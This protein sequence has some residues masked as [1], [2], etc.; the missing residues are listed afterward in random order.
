MPRGGIKFTF[1]I[2]R[3]ALSSEGPRNFTLALISLLRSFGV[4]VKYNVI[5]NPLILLL[6]ELYYV[7]RGYVIVFPFVKGYE[8]LAILF[9]MPLSTPS[10]ARIVIVNHDVHGLYESKGSLLWRFLIIMRSGK[11]LN[12]PLSRITMV[13]VSRYS[14]YSSYHVTGCRHVLVKGLI[15]YPVSRSHLRASRSKDHS[16]KIPYK[17]LIFAKAAKMLNEDF[18]NVIGKCFEGFVKQG[19]DFELT[20]MGGGSPSTVEAVKTIICKYLGS[21]VL[22]RTV[23]RFNVSNEERDRVIEQSD[24]MIYPL[25]T[26]GLGMPIF[27]A[28]MKGVPVLSARQTA[29]IEFVPLQIY[30]YRDFRYP[31]FCEALINAL[32]NYDKLIRYVENVKK[33]VTMITLT[34]LKQLL[35]ML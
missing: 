21:E 7:I 22:K 9:A 2:T 4:D 13:Y 32:V 5:A 35:Q 3:S 30:P 33:K 23:L 14:K 6:K 31:D 11:L 20:I 15:L 1:I 16:M 17:I 25:S 18:W 29:L 28:I 12:F 10:R 34:N 27:E 24:L 26:E 8:L 19:K